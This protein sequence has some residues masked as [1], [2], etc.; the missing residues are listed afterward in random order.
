MNTCRSSGRRRCESWNRLRV[1]AH[2]FQFC[3]DYAQATPQFGVTS[4]PHALSARCGTGTVV[5]AK[6]TG[7]AT[8]ALPFLLLTVGTVHSQAPQPA[9]SETRSP[10]SE[11]AHDFTTWLNHVTGSSSNHHRVASPPPLPRPR[12]AEAATTPVVSNGPPL[13]A[14]PAAVRP[15]KKIVAPVLIN[16]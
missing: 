14:A 7:A 16:D 3:P 1:K 11:I 2:Y 10:L 9:P 5:R 15:N 8:L 13:L 4:E 6:A 12:P